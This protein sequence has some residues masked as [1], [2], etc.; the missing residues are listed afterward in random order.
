[1][2][3]GV[4]EDEVV[5]MVD[6]LH[7]DNELEEEARAV[8]GDSDDQHCTYL[9]GYV[10]RQALYACG[11]C[12]PIDTEP[13]GVCLACTLTCHEGHVLYELYTKRHFRCDCGNN[14]FGSFK[15][16]L[17]SQKD[18]ENTMNKYNQNFRGVYCTCHRP[19]PDM[20][21]EIEDEMIQCIICE[22][23]YHSR[24]L[25]NLPPSGGDFQEMICDDCMTKCSFLQAYLSLSVPQQRSS[26]GPSQQVV[27]KQE[28]G[29]KLDVVKPSDSGEG[30]HSQAS[31]S[32]G[33]HSQASNSEGSHSQASNSEGSHSQASNSE[34]SHSQASNSE[35]IHSQASNS[36]GSHSQASNS[37][38]SH[39]QASNS[40]DS[41]KTC[42]IEG[43][44]QHNDLTVDSNNITQSDSQNPASSD[45]SDTV[46]STNKE[47]QATE[48]MIGNG[49]KSENSLA[50]CK[51]VQLQ[52][53]VTTID[54][55]ASYWHTGWRL[56]LCK[57]HKCMSLYKS[58]DVLYLT[59]ESDTMLA[60]EQ[61]GR[62]KRPGVS[63][64][65]SGMQALQNMGRIP[66]V[67][68]MHEYNDMKSELTEYLRD[69][70]AQGKVV[71]EEDI[72]NFFD[73]LQ[74][75]KRQRVGSENSVQYTC[76]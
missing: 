59:D 73:S 62:E 64:Y 66:Q 57:C 38:G 7:E 45:Q 40:E 63:S 70:V 19:Y 26:I 4:L 37:E 43:Q 48:T 58:L 39:S 21:D 55:K 76:R 68:V 52:A 33:I 12:S 60:Y 47:E 16:K 1:M 25:G 13:A 67:E 3:A 69:F 51:L 8:L 28:T 11:T 20:E 34:G 50:D 35:G 17:Y 54:N 71:T 41:S 61:R 49:V 6:V 72:R 29:I 18:P 32:E 46:K 27:S 36:E 65:E 10:K 15:C 14:N 5:S 53:S 75:R 2:D 44:E 74:S 23:W 30:S 42:S 24:H 56:N 22:D 9:A 31:N